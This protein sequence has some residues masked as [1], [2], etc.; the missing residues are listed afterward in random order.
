MAAVHSKATEL[1]HLAVGGRVATVMVTT[2]MHFNLYIRLFISLFITFLLNTF[3]TV[4]LKRIE[5]LPFCM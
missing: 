3:I 2:I 1:M 4:T 5:H